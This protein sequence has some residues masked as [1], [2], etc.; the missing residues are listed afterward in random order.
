MN[1]SSLLSSFICH[2]CHADLKKCVKFKKKFENSQTF[3]EC[4]SSSNKNTPEETDL[5][6]PVWVEL[7]LPEEEPT[8]IKMEP[9]MW[10]TYEHKEEKEMCVPCYQCSEMFTSEAE[11]EKHARDYHKRIQRSKNVIQNLHEENTQNQTVPDVINLPADLDLKDYEFRKFQCE[12][13][14]KSYFTKAQL[15]VHIKDYHSLNLNIAC[16][17]NGCKKKFRNAIRL[18]NHQRYKH[19]DTRAAK[20]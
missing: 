4:I 20:V 5:P 18:A 11:V 19:K 13:C 12:L 3:L 9:P 1:S 6:Q 7:P 14:T 16:P 15:R 8:V 17:I 2:Q 10:L